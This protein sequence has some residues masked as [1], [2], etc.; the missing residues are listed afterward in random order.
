MRRLN[1]SYNGLK[2]DLPD[3]LPELEQLTHLD[4]SYSGV[5]GPAKVPWQALKTQHPPP[6]PLQLQ[7][8][9]A[10]VG[11]MRSL[12]SLR[13]E[14]MQGHLLRLPESIA[15][16]EQLQEIRLDVEKYILPPPEV[17]RRGAQ[18]TV[19]FMGEVGRTGSSTFHR[20]NVFLLGPGSGWAS[21]R[22]TEKRRK[23]ELPK[24]SLIA[25][26]RQDVIAA[27]PENW[28][29]AR[30]GGA[31]ADADAGDI[32]ADGSSWGEA[33]S[34]CNRLLH[35]HWG[36]GERKNGASTR[37]ETGKSRIAH[38]NRLLLCSTSLSA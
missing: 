26:R 17:L 9:P 31:G 36:P 3:W 2:D 28:L 18:E 24:N 4:L 23:S 20:L 25:I 32:G 30:D 35:R 37:K 19:R 6:W 22:Q 11:E 7:M 8:V 16:L 14:G 5:S 10:V 1:L 29:V 27:E 13:A 15:N 12:Q 33:R 38:S 21:K 34:D